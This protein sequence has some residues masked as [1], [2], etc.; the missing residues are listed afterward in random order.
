[1][2]GTFRRLR[3]LRLPP[4]AAPMKNK[5]NKR[6]LELARATEKRLQKLPAII[7]KEFRA[8]SDRQ[9]HA[10]RRIEHAIE[11]VA[12]DTGRQRY[13]FELSASDSGTSDPTK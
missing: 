10:L 12:R 6:M 1:M 3:W 5:Y 9:V 4:Y 8:G 11:L 13:L 2:R 7:R